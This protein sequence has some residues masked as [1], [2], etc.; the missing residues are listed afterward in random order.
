MDSYEHTIE[1]REESG[2][3]SRNREDSQASE[4]TAIS[5]EAGLGAMTRFI[6]MIIERF[7]GFT[8]GAS[9]G[10]FGGRIAGSIFTRYFQ[11]VHLYELEDI[12]RF[13]MMPYTFAKYGVIAG[14]ILGITIIALLENNPKHICQ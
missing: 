8:V 12:T 10:W 2:T 14:A 11:P 9:I 6:V 7:F 3:N 5:P 4:T 13:G 1:I